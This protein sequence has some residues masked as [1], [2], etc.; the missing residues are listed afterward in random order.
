M[1]VEA[2]DAVMPLSTSLP[3]IDL[4]VIDLDDPGLAAE[5]AA[6]GPCCAPGGC[7][8]AGGPG[9]LA[10]CGGTPEEYY[11]LADLAN[12]YVTMENIK[13]F[14]AIVTFVTTLV[15]FAA[16]LISVITGAALATP[17]MVATPNFADGTGPFGGGG[18]DAAAPSPSSVAGLAPIPPQFS[19]FA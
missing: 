8:L 15:V 9:A 13:N 7:C 17:V 1:L 3:E 14:N 5:G 12:R 11:I 6:L 10:P 16:W 4:R 19:A 18:S 2:H